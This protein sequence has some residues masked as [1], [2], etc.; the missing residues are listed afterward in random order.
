M[1]KRKRK[2]IKLED[3]ILDLIIYTTLVLLLIITFYPM[4]Y[5]LVASFSNTRDLLRNPGI[6]LCPSEFNPQAYL[7]VFKDKSIYTGFINSVLLLVLAL[8]INIFLTVLAGYFMS[9]TNMVL[10]KPIVYMFLLPMF[11]GGGLIPTYL[12]VVG[13]GLKNSIWALILPG[14]LSIYNAIICK[15]AIEA[16]PISL[17]ESAYLDGANDIQVLFKIII[18]LIMPTVA[19][20]LLYYGVGHWN[21]WFNASIYITDEAKLPIQNILRGLLMANQQNQQTGDDY[22]AYAETIKYATIVVS[23]VPIICV[24]PF[25]QKYFVKGVMIGAVKG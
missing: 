23:A 12:N 3:V 21:A 7:L 6:L 4:W 8:P 5:V 9:A 10:K 18:P 19:V 13:M 11:F 24:Y 15:T 16:I 20:L 1:R 17:S 2:I 14:A 22:N 25:I